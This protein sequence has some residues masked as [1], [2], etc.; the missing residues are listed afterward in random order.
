MYMLNS[1]KNDNISILDLQKVRWP[2]EGT[3]RKDDKIFFIVEIEMESLKT[4]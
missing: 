1:I 3:L 2:G 4:E